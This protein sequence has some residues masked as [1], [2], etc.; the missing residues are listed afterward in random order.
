MFGNL[1][2]NVIAF[3]LVLGILVFV[4]EAG[5]FLVAK[6]FK[7]RVLVFSFGFGRRL[8]GFQKG[9]T[10]YR[11]SLIPLGGYVRMAG[12]AL[13]RE[14]NGAAASSAAT[15]GD[16]LTKPKWQRFLILFAG[17]AMNLLVAV[18]FLAFLFMAGTE[19]LRDS[20]PVIGTVLP[21]RPAAAAGL[22]TGDVVRAINDE[23]VNSWRDFQ[24]A[25][26]MAPLHQLRLS[27]ERDGEMFTTQVVPERIVTDYGVIGQIGA[28]AWRE[29][30]IGRVQPES[31]A[32][33]AGLQ[34]GDTIVAASGQ[35][36]EH[37]DELSAILTENRTEPTPLLVR[38]GQQEITLSLAPMQ[39]RS[40]IYPG[41][42]PPTIIRQLGF[43]AAVRE[44]VDQNQKMTRY[45]FRV[46]GRFF[47]LEG[48]AKDFSGPISI[49][50]ISGE[51]LRTGWKALVFLMATISLQLAILNL[52]PIPVLDGGHIFVLL[53]EG[54][55]GRELSMATKE[56]IQQF[57]FVILAT[58]MVVVLFNDVIQNVILMTRG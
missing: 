32:D 31:A 9:D 8:F 15:E 26:N 4:H 12:D 55:A 28:T 47:K 52:L 13:D 45:T 21:D 42:I 2:T 48:S 39:D 19:E 11:V 49:A 27:V 50:R 3:V 37:W 24:L 7:V 40:E 25:I 41:F 34:P 35:P 18:A 22:Q 36:V 17:P 20:R 44:S 33:R 38:R 56:R 1:A 51:M 58:L 30:E 29:L 53:I 10:D 5:H 43:G 57:G 6:L 14:E 16:Y 54:V 46:L 23:A